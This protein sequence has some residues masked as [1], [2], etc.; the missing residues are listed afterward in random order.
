MAGF[1]AAL[2]LR[3]FFIAA[4]RENYDLRSFQIVAEI[5]NR[6][7]NVYT[8]TS[9][10]NYAP[11]WAYLL[12]AIARVGALFGVPLAA[13]VTIVLLAVD[14]A[15]ARLIYRI[16]RAREA[17]RRRAA[18]ASLLFFAN[19]VSVFISSYSGMFDNVAILF[20]LVSATAMTGAAVRRGRA[21]F[22]VTA[23]I[24]IKHVAWFHPLLLPR[25]KPPRVSLAA[26]LTPY[27]V[28]F[29]A[30][31]PFWASRDRIRA[32]IF[33]YQSMG[34]PYGTEALRFLPFMPEW[35]TRALC[36]VAAVACVI[37]V[38]R[39]GLEF[40]RGCLLL[41]LVILIFLPGIAP[42]Y[43]VWPIAFGALYPSAGYAAYTAMVTLFLIHSPDAI[44]VELPHLPGW[45][46]PWWALVF[47][48]LWEVRRLSKS[49]AAS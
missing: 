43:F 10:Y 1:L 7:G 11:V 27:A 44:G 15:S 38:R 49:E 8:E 18:F 17:S 45:S 39:R 26:S 47:W 24:L 9:R 37:W 36:V 33:G 34:E 48:L 28:F 14:A 16:L 32:Q 22:G 5:V 46:G 31:L 41:F 25:R 29:A 6:G 2:L 13:G 21:V 30:L 42:Y 20:L 40:D 12:W 19:P 35:G 3:I 23:S 4:Q